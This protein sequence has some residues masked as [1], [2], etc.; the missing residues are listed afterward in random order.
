[1]INVPFCPLD[2]VINLTRNQ[3]SSYTGRTKRVTDGQ[4][5]EECHLD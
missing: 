1:M 3:E 4:E 5:V 2:G